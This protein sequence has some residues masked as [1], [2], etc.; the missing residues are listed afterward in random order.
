MKVEY[1][2]HMGSDLAVVNDARVSFSKWHNEFQEPSD[3]K[4][5]NYLADHDH[6]S[7]YSHS[8]VKFRITA[9]VFVARQLVKHH[10]GFSW[11]EESRRYVKHEPT[12]WEP[13]FRSA[14]ANK[15][16]GSGGQIVGP[17]AAAAD[18]IYRSAI[19][20]SAYAYRALLNLGVAEE[21]ARAV[22]PVAHNTTWIWTGSIAGWHRV[23]KLR[24]DSHAQK[25]CAE[26][27][28]PIADQ[29]RTLFPVAW[30]ALENANG[31]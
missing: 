19:R 28:K 1:L 11:N 20:G 26:I 27:V 13:V 24:L 8:F 25:E 30:D 14:A 12:F 29:V 21:Q 23:A 16:Q 6:W 31:S 22:L 4:L 9:P 5:L 15:K 18:W 2:D 3:R 7:P 10:V 17:R